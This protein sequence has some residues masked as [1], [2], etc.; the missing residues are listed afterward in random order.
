MSDEKVDQR[1]ET[2]GKSSHG[3]RWWFRIRFL[4]VTAKMSVRKAKRGISTREIVGSAP[5]IQLPEMVKPPSA[6][7]N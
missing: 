1:A 5:S 2:A 6:R 4:P 3:Y 7:G